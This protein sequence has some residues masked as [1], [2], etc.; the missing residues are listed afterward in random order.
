[1]RYLIVI[2]FLFLTSCKVQVED[3]SV[4]RM[5]RFI[6]RIEHIVHK[7]PEIF[8]PILDSVKLAIQ[9]GSQNRGVSASL[10]R[11]ADRDLVM[12]YIALLNPSGN[13]FKITL[14]DD[15][16]NP[17]ATLNNRNL[18]RWYLRTQAVWYELTFMVEDFTPT[19]PRP[20]IDIHE[21][22]WMVAHLSDGDK[23]KIRTHREIRV[24]EDGENIRNYW[25]Q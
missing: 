23:V 19:P 14:A 6:D 18:L 24:Y 3:R 4:E 2:A 13:I 16:G 22:K 10:I 7:A 20:N 25:E 1:M 17:I 15:L 21:V 12:V 11:P 5:H 8:E 9:D